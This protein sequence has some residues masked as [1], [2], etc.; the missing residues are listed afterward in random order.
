MAPESSVQ[1]DLNI[2]QVISPA[3]SPIY[4]NN[5]GYGVLK[6]EDEKVKSLVFRFFQIEDFHR[7]G[8]ISFNHYDV[9]RYNDIDLNDANSVRDYIDSLLYNMQKYAGYIARNYGLKEFFAEGS[10]VFWPFFTDIHTS[11]TSQIAQ[12]CMLKY[13][14]ESMQP[15]YCQRALN[16]TTT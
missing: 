16:I 8:L 12:V 9:M 6:F 5:P 2:V 13:F 7:L 1:D 14:N 15:S 11:Q 3:I 10:Q 4:N